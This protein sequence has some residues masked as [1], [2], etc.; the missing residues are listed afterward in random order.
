MLRRQSF[1]YGCS[2][3]WHIESYEIRALEL[4]KQFFWC[5]IF[6]SEVN[7][8]GLM[9]HQYPTHGP[10]KCVG[11]NNSMVLKATKKLRTLSRRAFMSPEGFVSG[12]VQQFLEDKGASMNRKNAA[13]IVKQCRVVGL[14]Y[15]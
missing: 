4:T 3:K 6:P 13:Y 14:L 8:K 15:T 11:I 1:T 5:D 7:Y 10:W 12:T 9:S 2:A